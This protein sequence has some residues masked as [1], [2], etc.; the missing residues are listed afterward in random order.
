MNRLFLI[1]VTSCVKSPAFSQRSMTAKAKTKRHHNILWCLFAFYDF[2][3]SLVSGLFV[4]GTKERLVQF[5]SAISRNFAPVFGLTE[6]DPAL[7]R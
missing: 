6:S 4:R 3:H 2:L 5:L 1:I 7:R